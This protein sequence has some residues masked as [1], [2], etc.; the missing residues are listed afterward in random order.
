[1]RAGRAGDRLSLGAVFLDRD[2]VVNRKA[3][4][5][6][7]VTSWERFQFLPGA[8]EG[9]RL[10]AEAGPPIVVVTNQRGIARGRISEA[11]LA[12]VHERMSAAVAEAGGRI[13]AIYHCPHEGGCDCRK[14][15]TA[16]FTRAARDLGIELDAS[17]VVGDRASDMEA[18]TRI[19]ALRVL[20]GGHDEPMP[21]V[22]HRAD[23]LAAAARWLVDQRL[24][25]SAISE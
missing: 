22:D 17:A 2:G 13:D 10:L 20:V 3:P 18:A 15:G 14:P 7:Y 1:V 21:P 9:L 25:A 11:E 23:D 8:L 6:D 19:G 24:R 4:E 5:G 16:L 12:D